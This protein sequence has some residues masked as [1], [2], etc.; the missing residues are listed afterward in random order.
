MLLQQPEGGVCK[1]S[2]N[3]VPGLVC[4]GGLCG[5]CENDRQC[6]ARNSKN[7]C[8]N[9]TKDEPPQCHHKPLLDRRFPHD[10]TVLLDGSPCQIS[11]SKALPPHPLRSTQPSSLI[12]TTS[13][14][15]TF[16]MLQPLTRQTSSLRWL[17]S[18]PSSLLLRREWG[19][20]AFLCQCISQSVTFLPT[21]AFHC[22]RPLYWEE[23]SPTTISICGGGIP[24]P[25]G[26][27]STTPPA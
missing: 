2:W 25:T 4:I 14:T 8:M 24:L 13:G 1:K 6:M 3:C 10:D 7:R 5:T 22:Q 23:P 12:P 15:L 21:M 19:V 17:H 20:A 11:T 27:W 18:S 26:H 16:G 9:I